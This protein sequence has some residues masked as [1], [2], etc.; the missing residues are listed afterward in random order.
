MDPLQFDSEFDD[1]YAPTGCEGS[2]LTIEEARNTTSRS[3][4]Q[5]KRRLQYAG[6]HETQSTAGGS[7]SE[8]GSSHKVFAAILP[9]KYNTVHSRS[10]SCGLWR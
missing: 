5:S 7:Q 2:K 8:R 6:K 3:A 10:T 9:S 4:D 1:E